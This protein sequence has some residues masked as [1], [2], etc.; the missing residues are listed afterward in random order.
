[1]PG[2]G[3]EPTN[4]FEA[5]ILSWRL[6][7]CDARYPR[8]RTRSSST[9]LPI[10]Q[11]T[12]TTCCSHPG[13]RKHGVRPHM[14]R[15]RARSSHPAPALDFLD[16]QC[17]LPSATRRPRRVPGSRRLPRGDHGRHPCPPG[18]WPERSVLG[19]DPRRRRS[20][21]REPPRPRHRGRSA[22]AAPEAGEAH[23]RVKRARPIGECCPK[24]TF[25]TVALFQ[26]FRRAGCPEGCPK[27]CIT[28][29]APPKPEAFWLE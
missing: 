10:R 24:T 20:A 2:V 29:T 1:M 12:S 9:A 17:R 15:R 6:S 13:A 21:Q 14:R 16:A 4:P 28:A 7:R 19:H 11:P 8:R 18:A 5:P 26:A 25:G 22:D 27:A 3:V 23:D